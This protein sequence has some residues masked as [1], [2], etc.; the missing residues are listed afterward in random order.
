[1]RGDV[2]EDLVQD[3]ALHLLELELR[4]GDRPRRR[5]RAR[6]PAV[7]VVAQPPRSGRALEPARVGE[8]L[9]LPRV[10][11]EPLGERA[12]RVDRRDRP[13]RVRHRR[14]VQEPAA[15][16]RARAVHV[17]LLQRQRDV[18]GQLAGAVARRPRICRK[19]G[20]DD[21]AQPARPRRQ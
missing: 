4:P 8:P 19:H 12:R 20:A 9:E 14:L 21:G 2:V 1:M 15:H 10:E 13:A 18:G 11:L 17:R 6:L 16:V 7:R 5:P 3:P